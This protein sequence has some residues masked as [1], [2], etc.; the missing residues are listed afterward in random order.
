MKIVFFIH[1]FENYWLN[2]VNELRKEFKDV[3]FV[4]NKETEDLIPH[5]KN[6]EGIV[7]WRLRNYLDI[8]ENLKIVFFP[9]TGVNRLNFTEI[10]RRQIMI[11]N[12]HGN[13]KYVAEHMFRLT[14]A[15]LGN[16]IEHHNDMTKGIWFRTKDVTDNAWISI[17]DMKCGILGTGGIGKEIAKILKPFDCY[18]TGFKKNPAD[19]SL[20][21]FD[22]ITNLLDRV[23]EK[24]EIIFVCLPLTEETKGIIDNEVIEKMLGKYLINAGRGEIIEEEA[25]YKGLSEGILAGAAID[26]WYTYPKSKG[27]K[28][29]PSRYPI[30]ELDNVILSPHISSN[31]HKSRLCVADETIENVRTFLKEGRPKS[32]VNPDLMY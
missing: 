26:A 1:E 22:E 2:K 19:S 18:I 28:M 12:V 30:H 25:L 10:K 13:G 23:I 31:T 24:S 21:N 5:I 29:Y 15:L 20:I 16:T 17:R 32:V 6:A 3:E 27:E 11:S 4:T 8:A 9:Y 14:L 7:T